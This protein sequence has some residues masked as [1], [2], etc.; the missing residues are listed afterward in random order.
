M[1]HH[2]PPDPK[3]LRRWINKVDASGDCW[4][5]TAATTDTGYGRFSLGGRTVAAHRA[6]VELL[7]GPI[8]TG[9]EIDHL[10]RKRS[11]VNPDHLALVTH[12]ENLRRRSPTQGTANGRAKRTHCPQGHPYSGENLRV[13]V[14]GNGSRKR[15]CRACDVVA[16]RRYRERQK[17]EVAA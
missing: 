9:L 2:A 17:A 5:W 10:C 14:L 12:A 15:G 1:Q 4:E 13:R 6:G 3:A 11:C 7:V 16:R 8:P